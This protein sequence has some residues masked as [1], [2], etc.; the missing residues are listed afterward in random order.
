VAGSG[1][2]A[3]AAI[4]ISVRR[5]SDIENQ[6]VVEPLTAAAAAVDHPYKHEGVFASGHLH[7]RYFMC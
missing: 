1:A 4:Y 2:S 3:Q 7:Y 6:M 5:A